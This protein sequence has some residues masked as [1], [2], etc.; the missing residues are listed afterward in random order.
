MYYQGQSGTRAKGSGIGLAIAREIVEI[1][2]G[3][4]A[5]ESREGRG[6][7]FRVTLPVTQEGRERDASQADEAMH[8][9]GDQP[10]DLQLVG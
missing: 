4:I 6:T 7:T 10:P 2:G 9:T 3:E 1:H 5:V 8:P